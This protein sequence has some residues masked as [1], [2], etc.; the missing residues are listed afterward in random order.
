M[1]KLYLFI[2]GGL[3]SLFVTGAGY[4]IAPIEVRFME[5]LTSNPTLIGLAFGL[6]SILFAVLSVWFGRLSDQ[7]GRGRFIF[8]GTLIGVVYP[9][10]YAS[11][12]NIFHYMGVKFAWAGATAMT[13]PILTAYLQ[14]LVNGE[15]HQAIYFSYLYGAQSLFGAGVQ[16]L[17]GYFGE[18]YGLEAPYMLVSGLFLLGVVFSFVMMFLMKEKKQTK[19]EEKRDFLFGIKYILKKRELKYY[20]VNNSVFGLNWGI[21]AMLWPLIIFGIA[22]SDTITG[23]VFASMGLTAFFVLLGI[24]FF[25]DKVGEIRSVGFAIFLMLV[26]GIVLIFTQNLVLFWIFACVFAVGEATYGPGQATIFTKYVE[27]KY[28]GE[29][30]GVDHV[31][32]RTLNSLSPFVAGIMLSFFS[33]QIVLSFFVSFL[34]VATLYNLASYKKLISKKKK[35]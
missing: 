25:V 19:S 24:G 2:L 27:N 33:A 34:A 5:T 9:F 1:K 32:D 10:L 30:V 3:L 17:G 35:V 14:D 8:I 26:S 29:I 13:G 4:V 31:F 12:L 7:Y 28:R 15:K 23:S 22:G 20:F 16:F 18:N 21:K 11:S 6:G